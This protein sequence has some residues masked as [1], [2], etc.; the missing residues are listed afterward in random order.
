MKLNIAGVMQ[1]IDGVY[2]IPELKNNL[3]SMGQL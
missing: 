2:Y 3:L 1:K